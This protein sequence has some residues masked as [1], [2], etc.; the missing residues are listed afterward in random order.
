M[1]LDIPHLYNTDSDTNNNPHLNTLFKFRAISEQ[2][3]IIELSNLK[4]SKSTGLD[5]VRARVLKISANIIA[6]YITWIFNLSLKKGIFVDEWKK[7]WVSPVYKSGN[8]HCENYR[9]ISI[10]PV[11][12]KILERL[13]YQSIVRISQ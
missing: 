7:A 1:E 6:P 3:V 8:R 10:L 9:P 5:T 2:E 13:V 4:V 11:I 12:S